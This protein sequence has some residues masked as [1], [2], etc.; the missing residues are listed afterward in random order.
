MRGSYNPRPMN[1]DPFNDLF[2]KFTGDGRDPWSC[3]WNPLHPSAL[4]CA[5]LAMC[6]MVALSLLSGG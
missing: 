6:A 5:L 1:H 4:L 2:V 3:L